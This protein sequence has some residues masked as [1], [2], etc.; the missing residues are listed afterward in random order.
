MKRIASFTLLFLMA[1]AIPV[2]ADN[3]VQPIDSQ[4]AAI[5]NSNQAPSAK[6]VQ[7]TPLIQ[8]AGANRADQ[9]ASYAKMMPK[10]DAIELA[11]KALDKYVPAHNTAVSNLNIEM[12]QQNA[13][14][15][16]NQRA[17]DAH[18][19]SV[20]TYPPD[21]PGAC[22]GY[23]AEAQR[24]NDD[25][26]R[27]T[28]YGQQLNNKRDALNTE[29][30]TLDEMQKNLSSDVLE[31]TA[32]Q[33]RYNANVAQNEA[34]IVLLLNTLKQ[35][36]RSNSDCQDAIKHSSDETMV[37][38]CRQM[39][40]GNRVPSNTNTNRGTGTRSFGTG[41]NPTNEQEPHN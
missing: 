36:L 21:N 40:D 12:A 20:C 37:E 35:I 1:L 26:N 9:K 41:A 7:L 24:L 23:N 16:A 5:V 39:F 8:T 14:A 32:W 22:A 11:S 29:K 31:Y 4:V 6:A 38:I 13:D 18:N 25:A 27:I 3:D 30:A 2:F 34:N 15:A 10:K 33:K 17:Q 28:A 19:A